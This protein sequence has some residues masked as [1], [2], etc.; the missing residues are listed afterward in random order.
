[1]TLTAEEKRELVTRF[2]KV[3]TDTGATEVQIAMVT[4]RIIAAMVLSAL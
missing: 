1:M 3:E 2:G 4:R